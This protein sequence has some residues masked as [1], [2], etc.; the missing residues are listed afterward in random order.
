MARP[1][2]AERIDALLP[3]VLKHMGEKHGALF[4]IQRDWARLV[5]RRLA[6]HT[7]PVGLRRGALTVHAHRP[8]DGH[9]LTYQKPELLE[10]LAALAP[11]KVSE[12]VIRPGDVGP[13]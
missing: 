3:N 12:I 2:K 6:A 9:A 13:R 4:D 1:D 11:G 8:G 5:G 7:R 10:R